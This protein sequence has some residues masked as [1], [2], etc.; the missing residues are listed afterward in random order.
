M[1]GRSTVMSWDILGFF[2]EFVFIPK[3]GVH[4]QQIHFLFGTEKTHF[5]TGEIFMPVKVAIAL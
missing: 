4:S 3:N 2:C 1:P 5:V